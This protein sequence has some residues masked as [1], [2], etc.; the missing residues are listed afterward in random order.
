MTRKQKEAMLRDAV[1]QF[2]TIMR[3]NGQSK[4]RLN[5][6]EDKAIEKMYDEIKENIDPKF[7]VEDLDG[8]ELG[9]TVLKE[10]AIK[11]FLERHP[12]F[13]KKSIEPFITEI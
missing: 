3:E 4:S 1:Q 10:E 13:D 8:S 6:F 5:Q 12:N 2:R 11:L 9:R 7:I